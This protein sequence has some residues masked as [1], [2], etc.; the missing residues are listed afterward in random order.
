MNNASPL[1]LCFATTLTVPSRLMV[2]FS[3]GAPKDV[4]DFLPVRELG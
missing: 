4:R 2:M 1:V 3:G